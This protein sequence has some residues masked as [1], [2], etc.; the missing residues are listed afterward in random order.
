MDE[1]R[2]R[3]QRSSADLAKLSFFEK[4][5]LDQSISNSDEVRAA[6]CFF[7]VG[8]ENLLSL[9]AL[10]LQLNIELGGHIAELAKNMLSLINQMKTYTIKIPIIYDL[11]A[12]SDA[13]HLFFFNQRKPDENVAKKISLPKNADLGK[14]SG[15]T[16]QLQHHQ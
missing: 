7:V 1:V 3:S 5:V 12:Y 4:Y 10:T 6:P 9:N 15:L 13:R 16:S 8:G 14:N 11:R 2:V